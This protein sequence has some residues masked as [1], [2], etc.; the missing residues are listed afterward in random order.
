MII[1]II[2]VDKINVFIA[3]GSIICFGKNVWL[4]ECWGSIRFN[5]IVLFGYMNVGGV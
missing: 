5:Y 1:M 3:I 2:I 4:N